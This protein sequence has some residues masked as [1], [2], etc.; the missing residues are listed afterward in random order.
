M[1]TALTA[2]GIRGLVRQFSI[3]L[4]EFGRVRFDLAVPELRWAI[5]VDVHPRH[6]ETL[7]QLSDDRRDKAAEAIGWSTSR[8]S[9]DEYERT[10]DAR[11]RELVGIYQDLRRAA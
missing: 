11:V 4:P 8:I 6:H 7:G 9:R 1:F 2:A 3:T 5:E 10:L